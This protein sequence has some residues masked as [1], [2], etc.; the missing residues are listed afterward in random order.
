[1]TRNMALLALL[2]SSVGVCENRIAN[3]DFEDG[4]RHWTAPYWAKLPEGGEIVE[5]IVYSGKRAW[6]FGNSAV[7]E[8]NY[9]VSETVKRDP[10]ATY[11]LSLALRGENLQKDGVIARLFCRANGKILPFA[12]YDNG[13]NELI[14]AEGTFDWKVMKAVIKPST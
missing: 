4:F 12:M 6:R 7:K 2:L 8:M 10:E 1:M 9:I 11:T 5:D 13:V 3:G 14:R